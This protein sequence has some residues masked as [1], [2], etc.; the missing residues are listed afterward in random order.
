V[1]VGGLATGSCS[2]RSST[3]TQPKQNYQPDHDDKATHATVAGSLV[4]PSLIF[5]SA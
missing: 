2:C 3:N 4:P 1:V 5:L